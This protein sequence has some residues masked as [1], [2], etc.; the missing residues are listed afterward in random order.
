M[1]KN[2]SESSCKHITFIDDQ[3]QNI[4]LHY[5][6]NLIALSSIIAIIT[7]HSQLNFIT[8]ISMK[9]G[10]QR[11]KIKLY[12]MDENLWNSFHSDQCMIIIYFTFICIHCLMNVT[13]YIINDFR[14]LICSSKSVK[15]YAGPD[16]KMWIQTA[17][18]L[19]LFK[20]L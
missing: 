8:L 20:S 5:L 1:Y 19:S 15:L 4:N 14:V 12:Q 10:K 9:K 11:K 7:V 18:C 2:S 13:L 16:T 6:S 3:K 17:F